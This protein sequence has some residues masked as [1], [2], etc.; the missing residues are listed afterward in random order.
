MLTYF[1]I[2]T[3]K[4]YTSIKGNKEDENKL[5]IP[6]RQIVLEESIQI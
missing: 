3:A 4:F 5:L 6:Y 1:V 2:Q